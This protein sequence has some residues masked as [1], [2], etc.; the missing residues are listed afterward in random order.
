MLDQQPSSCRDDIY[1]FNE[2]RKASQDEPSRVRGKLMAPQVQW[3]DK[4]SL[5]VWGWSSTYL[6]LNEGY[7]VFWSIVNAI[8]GV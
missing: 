1:R 4:Y 8:A 7:D 6:T 2:Y 3:D 5:S